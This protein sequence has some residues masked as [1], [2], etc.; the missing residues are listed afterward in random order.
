[1]LLFKKTKRKSFLLIAKLAFTYRLESQSEPILESANATSSIVLKEE[2]SGLAGNDDSYQPWR[3]WP[4]RLFPRFHTSS[5]PIKPTWTV[6]TRSKTVLPSDL[7]SFLTSTY[8]SPSLTAAPSATSDDVH[9]TPSPTASDYVGETSSIYLPSND[10]TD[11]LTSL[12]S[13]FQSDHLQ[14]SVTN[15]HSTPSI[16]ELDTS[17]TIAS[18]SSPDAFEPISSTS[19]FTSSI[20]STSSVDPLETSSTVPYE[21]GTTPSPN[22]NVEHIHRSGNNRIYIIIYK[23]IITAIIRIV[24]TDFFL[25]I[26]RSLFS[27][28]NS[29]LPQRTARR[30]AK[31]KC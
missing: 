12:Q 25:I 22:D 23:L 6:I 5:D 26:V 16:T 8:S 10:S 28:E 29:C 2:I 1:M 30:N 7:S 11:I 13:S 21:N 31:H 15:E 14:T 20:H 24:T 4:D 3:E 9:P 27:P 17:F 18:S 19:Q